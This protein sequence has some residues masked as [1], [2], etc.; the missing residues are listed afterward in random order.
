MRVL[1]FGT[2]DGGR[3]P[4][5]RVLQE[6]L[7]ECG[8][9][10]VECN[11]PLGIETSDRVRLLRHP[12]LTPIAGARLGAAW[13]RLWRASRLL[14]PVDAVVVGYLGQLDVHLA[15][16]LWGDVPIVLDHLTSASETAI[17]RAV[18]SGLMIRLLGKLDRAALRAAD[19]A[20]VDTEEHLSLLP[21]SVRDR[22]VVVPVGAS[23]KWFS[24]PQPRDGTS[25]GVIFY[26][27]FT[28]AQGAPIIGEAIRLL[29]AE[30][31]RI[32]FTLVGRGQD[33]LATHQAAAANAGVTWV[34]WVPPEALP[35]LVARHEVCLGIFGTG[36]KSMRV[37]PHKVYQG[38]AAGCAIVT[39]DTP[40][41]RRALA[42]A[43]VFLPPG[44]AQALAEAL[45]GLLEEPARLERL[46]LASYRRA[47]EAF[48]PAV[49]VTPLRER[50]E[51][52]VVSR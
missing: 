5:V 25:L 2:Y 10:I 38:A 37:V 42:D 7:T 44:S 43:A 52:A 4:R 14:P 50:L 40:P 11:L 51:A 47:E 9:Q 39:S 22:G 29:S 16:R 21:E 35:A 30:A 36:P 49:V 3:H 20:C 34:D 31:G 8:H 18:S 17:D 32:R 15:R 28:P 27:L 13:W 45:R 1:F 41:Q 23:R 26:G 46:R 24:P 6:G 19:I 48:R 12:W 33:F